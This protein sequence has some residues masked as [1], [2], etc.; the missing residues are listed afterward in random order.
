[1]NGDRLTAGFADDRLL[2]VSFL[3]RS[4]WPGLVLLLLLLLFLFRQLLL[5]VLFL[6]LLA[7]LVSHASS[8]SAIMTRHGE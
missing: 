4:F 1:V 8:L 2:S 6:V 3:L 7:T 5:F